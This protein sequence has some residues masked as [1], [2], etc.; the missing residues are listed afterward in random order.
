M[1]KLK[2]HL[3]ALGTDIVIGGWYG[4]SKTDGG[5]AHT[6]VGQ[7]EY[8]KNGKVRLANINVAQYLY[9]DPSEYNH[10]RA[11]GVSIKTI[12][13]FP[14]SGD[15]VA[16]FTQMVKDRETAIEIELRE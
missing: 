11:N 8:V 9:G 10:H 4:Y 2:S 7:A 16:I 14:V 3:D 6:T 12:M 13:V 15:Q 1:D 5:W